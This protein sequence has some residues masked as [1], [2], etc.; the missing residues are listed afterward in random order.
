MRTSIDLVIP[1]YNAVGI[2]EQT[3]KIISEQQLP[4]NCRF[5]VYVY[6]DASTDDTASVLAGLQEQYDFLRVVS[7][8]ENVG[9]S[10][11]RNNGANAG[12]G[13]I[14][15]MCDADCR[16]TRDDAI[17]EFVADIENGAD[18]VI[19]M[20]EVEGQGFWSRYT[21][22][23]LPERIE[24]YKQQG[25]M[26][27]GTT[28]NIAIR[29]STFEALGG[30]PS[31]YEKYGFEDKDFLIRLEKLTEK[32]SLRPDIRVS[33]DDD[34]TLPVVCRK[35]AEAGEFT[36]PIFRSQYPE[37]YAILPYAR[38]DAGFGGMRRMMRPASGVI[39]RLAQIVG[40]LMLSLP[41][42]FA[43]QRA[44]VRAAMCAAYFD[45]TAR[46]LRA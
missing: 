21:N 7:T 30:Y 5:R 27:F 22:S 12:S 34:F 38:C 35:F 10:E 18:A 6:E 8:G 19:G 4:E 29:R 16:Y 28:Q 23:V 31:E 39:R 9:R 42:P 45:G 43:V 17:R 44:F 26:A 46:R 15:I 20:V 36:A 11:A 40:S 1:A 37:E 41:L 24:D 13:S 25:L 2:I 3:L 32:V 33:H 14:I